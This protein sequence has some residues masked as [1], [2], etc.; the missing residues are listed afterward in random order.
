MGTSQKRFKS[1]RKVFLM[2]ILLISFSVVACFAYSLAYSIMPK[3]ETPGRFKNTFDAPFL[4]DTEIANA[5]IAVP[6]G[7]KG[8]IQA[9]VAAGTPKLLDAARNGGRVEVTILL[10]FVSYSPELTQTEVN[11]DPLNSSGLVL[12]IVT[13]SDRV[14][15]INELIDYEPKGLLIIRENETLAVKTTI[16][17]PAD[18]LGSLQDFYLS[19]V[20]MAANVPILEKMDVIIH[21]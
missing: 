20:G 11:I 4:S 21:G 1:R 19:C 13:Y 14:I 17:F 5:S 6:Y 7:V 3:E 15:N 16:T 10:H 18:V 9:T 2:G 8:Y 12:K